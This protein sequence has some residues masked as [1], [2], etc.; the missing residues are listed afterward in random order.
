M[1]DYRKDWH[2]YALEYVDKVEQTLQDM[3]CF[4]DIDKFNLNLLGD[5][6]SMYLK[7]KKELD[8]KGFVVTD[9]KGRLVAN[10]CVGLVKNQ[11]GVIIALM[12]ELSISLRQ[13]RMLHRDEMVDPESPISQLF[14]MMNE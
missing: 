7:A 2:P 1:V 5:S 13:R 4:E 11:Q 10:P 6:I 14:D 3:G 9:Q 8:E 12:K